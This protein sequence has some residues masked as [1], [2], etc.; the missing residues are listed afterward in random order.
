MLVWLICYLFHSLRNIITL[1]QGDIQL[2]THSPLNKLLIH[3]S[4]I[5]ILKLRTHL[6][7]G[8]RGQAVPAWCSLVNEAV[9]GYEAPPGPDADCRSCDVYTPPPPIH[10]H[11]C[12]MYFPS[13][14]PLISAKFKNFNTTTS[15]VSNSPVMYKKIIGFLY[16]SFWGEI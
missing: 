9:V 3:F 16:Q 12:H 14:F 5:E 1:C 15:L 7:A 10:S 6:Q 11:C 4:H 13:P 2:P 8:Q